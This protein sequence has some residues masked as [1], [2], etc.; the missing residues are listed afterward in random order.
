MTTT[1]EKTT[2]GIDQILEV[3]ENLSHSQGYYARLLENILYAKD[4]DP[5]SYDNIVSMLESKNFTDPV[6]IVMFFEGE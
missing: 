6:D 1:T 4:N 5:N 3:I 2:Y